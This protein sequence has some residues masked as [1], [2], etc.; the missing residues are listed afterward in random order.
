M[1]VRTLSTE[2]AALPYREW[3]SC[4]P[5]SASQ[6]LSTLTY[7]WRTQYTGDILLVAPQTRQ[8]EAARTHALETVDIVYSEQNPHLVILM[9]MKVHNH[10]PP[11]QESLIFS[12]VP[13]SP[14]K[15]AKFQRLLAVPD[16]PQDRLLDRGSPPRRL[17]HSINRC[18]IA[19]SLFPDVRH[20]EY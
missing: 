11:L 17:L 19:G 16:A 6:R 7:D 8:D 9:T 4:P 14:P 18:T 1:D 20:L 3:S 12:L 10:R 2:A 15:V 5:E 13:L